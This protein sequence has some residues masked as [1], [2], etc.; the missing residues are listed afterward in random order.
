MAER[1]RLM[2]QA[3]FEAHLV[4]HP[5]TRAFLLRDCPEAAK[6]CPTEDAD[7][8]LWDMPAAQRSLVW[9]IA[10]GHPSIVAFLIDHLG[11]R[12]DVG[13]E[14]PRGSGRTVVPREL[15]FARG[16]E[17]VIEITEEAYSNVRLAHIIGGGAA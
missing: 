17:R 7:V 1:V 2:R 10:D 4:G 9:A 14:F 6:G 3:L 16:D 13:T 5:A 11:V 8:C 12:V 15:A